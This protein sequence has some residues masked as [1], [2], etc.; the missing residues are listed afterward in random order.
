MRDHLNRYVDDAGNGHSTVITV[1]GRPVAR[2][3]PIDAPADPY[4]DLR[5]RGIL[6]EPTKPKSRQLGRKR[7]K[8]KGT[9]SDLVKE[10]RR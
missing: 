3:V 1:R 4:E 5:R 6:T 7:I 9:V 2:L 8:A 10:Q